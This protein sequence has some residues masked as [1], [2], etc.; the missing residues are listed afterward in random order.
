[1][2][3]TSLIHNACGTGFSE[4]RLDGALHRHI[5]KARNTRHIPMSYCPVIRGRNSA[6]R[7][8]EEYAGGRGI[9]LVIPLQL[10]VI[11]A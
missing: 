8:R 6:V 7:L 2:M 10:P 3:P 5:P 9:V 1:M 11:T 4:D